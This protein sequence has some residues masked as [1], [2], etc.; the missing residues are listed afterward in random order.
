MST[1]KPVFA[2]HFAAGLTALITFGVP[3]LT[4]AQAVLAE[5]DFNNVT[6]IQDGWQIGELLTGISLGLPFPFFVNP[7]PASFDARLQFLSPNPNGDSASGWVAPAK[8]LGDQRAAMGGVLSFDLSALQGFVGNDSIRLSDGVL[9]LF[10]RAPPP[11]SVDI[12]EMTS[13]VIPLDP[14]AG[15]WTAGPTR[16][17]PRTPTTRAEMMMVLSD[18]RSLAIRADYFEPGA[19]SI[20]TL[21]NVRLIS[22]VPEPGTWA[23]MGAGLLVLGQMAARRRHDRH[24]TPDF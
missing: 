21:D 12:L 18:L 5:S 13:Y 22:A 20:A 7:N 6:A 4:Q 14:D 16:F 19:E 10:Y 9:E 1:F 3:G 23:L 15:W 17:D 24:Q 8:F 2:H 11:N